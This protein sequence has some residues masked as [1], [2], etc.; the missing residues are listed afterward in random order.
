MMELN[1]L[2]VKKTFIKMIETTKNLYFS[3]TFL[4]FH[5]QIWQKVRVLQK[6]LLPNKNDY[7]RISS[8]RIIP[9]GDS[10]DIISFHCFIVA[11][12]INC[13]QVYCE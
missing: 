2:I 1:F 8:G 6:A 4:I 13:M 5:N 3:L 10:Q 9:F 11:W 7:G 12:V